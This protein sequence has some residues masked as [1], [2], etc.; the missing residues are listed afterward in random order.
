MLSLFPRM[1]CVS[2][3]ENILVPSLV[4]GLAILA[5]PGIEDPQSPDALAAGAFLMIRAPVFQAIGTFE[6]IRGEI[7]DDF[8]LARSRQGMR[9]PRRSLGCSRIAHVRLY[10]GNRHAFWAMTKNIL[11]GIHGRY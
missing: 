8:A 6:S 9:L 11:V 4:G 2:L 7:A 5:T 10:K 1:D 3:W